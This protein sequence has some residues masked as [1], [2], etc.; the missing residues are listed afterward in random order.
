M[1]RRAAAAALSCLGLAAVLAGCAATPPDKDPVQI[2]LNDLD[3][4][5]TRIERVVANRSILDLASQVEEQRADLRSLH[6]GVDQ[7]RH[8]LQ[9]NRKQERDL[10]ADLDARLKKLEASGAAAPAGAA[11]TPASGAVA[12]TDQSAAAGGPAAAAPAQAGD[13]QAHYEAAFTLLRKAEYDQ[14]IGAFKGFLSA[15]PQSQYAANAQY[16][17]GETYYVKGRTADALQAFQAVVD[18]YGQSRKL[19]DALLKVGYCDDDLKQWDKAKQVLGEV[20]AKY[21]DT[22][23]GHLAVQRLKKMQSEPH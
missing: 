1:T 23:A 3:T 2:K 14:A 21:P 19:P 5:L 11:Q 9:L 22:P 20:A 8:Q 7:L 18:D 4:R 12:G 13:D 15:Y 6:D 16:W 17:L 10:Y